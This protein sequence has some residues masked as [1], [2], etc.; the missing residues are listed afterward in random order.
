MLTSARVD[1]NE[2]AVFGP[3]RLGPRCDVVE[4]DT[5]LHLL[6]RNGAARG[7]VEACLR[8]GAD[9]RATNA[10]GEH[11]LGLSRKAKARAGQRRDRSPGA[12]AEAADRREVAA[13]VAAVVEKY[14]RRAGPAPRVPQPSGIDAPAFKMHC[15]VF[16]AGRGAAAG[17]DV[18]IPRGAR[19]RLT[20]LGRVAVPPR[21]DT[22][23]F[24]GAH[25]PEL[26]RVAA[27]PRGATCVFRGA[28]P[29]ELGRAGQ[30]DA[31]TA[32]GEPRAAVARGAGDAAAHAQRA[33]DGPRGR[34]VAPRGA[35]MSGGGGRGGGAPSLRGP[36][37]GRGGRR[38]RPRGRARA[39]GARGRARGARRRVRGSRGADAGAPAR[40][41]RR[42]A[43]ARG[44]RRAAR[45]VRRGR[46]EAERTPPRGVRRGRPTRTPRGHRL[47]RTPPP[48]RRR[49]RAVDAPDAKV[50]SSQ[51]PPRPRG[52]AL[53]PARPPR[54]SATRAGT[55]SCSRGTRSS[56]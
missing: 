23:V 17:R 9:V 29:P 56:S 5:L 35:A 41:E 19:R 12:A 14:A 48:R 50:R 16:W 52:R 3:V 49:D 38:R 6:L 37:R 15:T 33:V 2:E 32:T 4:G 13:M 7:A 20:E 11:C 8:M 26:G 27:P 53:R 45:A 18:R 30:Y 34:R 28:R 43:G 31:A 51:P 54:K 47:E 24:R 55:R 39:R 25:P 44:A 42:D 21:G 10:R 22:C 40:R 46:A 1:E 36:G